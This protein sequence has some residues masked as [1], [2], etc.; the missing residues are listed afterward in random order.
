MSP[1]KSKEQKRSLVR[2]RSTPH[3]LA[4][5]KEEAT[6]V[7]EVND[8]LPNTVPSNTCCEQDS[9][10]WP[11]NRKKTT[12]ILALVP[13][14]TCQLT[15][16]QSV[17]SIQNILGELPKRN[18]IGDKGNLASNAELPA[19]WWLSWIHVVSRAGCVPPLQM[20]RWTEGLGSCLWSTG[21]LKTVG[22]EPGMFGSNPRFVCSLT[23]FF[24]LLPV[25]WCF[26][27]D[28][29]EVPWTSQQTKAL[30]SDSGCPASTGEPV[31]HFWIS[32]LAM[33][34]MKIP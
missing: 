32:Q 28:C 25:T 12:V 14:L 7:R 33:V 31:T 1:P 27:V 5:S 19:C 23:L 21:V 17:R 34:H 10:G 29:S 24:S 4:S 16:H 20:H 2:V 3:L 26:W 9:D 13:P 22:R 8:Q 18:T 30:T 6:S 15:L 11:R